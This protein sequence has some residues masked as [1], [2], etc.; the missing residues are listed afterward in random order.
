MSLALPLLFFVGSR[1]EGRDKLGQEDGKESESGP[2]LPRLLLPFEKSCSEKLF[3]RRHPLF[4]LGS[5]KGRKGWVGGR[6]AEDAGPPS[7]GLQE[8]I[9]MGKVEGAIFLTLPPPSLP[10]DSHSGLSFQFCAL[11]FSRPCVL[12]LGARRREEKRRGKK[13]TPYPPNSLFF[14]F[15][16]VLLFSPSAIDCGR[17]T[18]FFPPFL[19]TPAWKKKWRMK[20]LTRL[21]V[22]RCTLTVLQISALFLT[23]FVSSPGVCRQLLL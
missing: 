12:G 20:P 15:F 5:E 13:G 1:G 18:P 4:F 22:A 7:P 11:P 6:E 2:S 23:T 21:A 16:F 8:K 10:L 3:P 14:F 9:Q 17:R 19:R